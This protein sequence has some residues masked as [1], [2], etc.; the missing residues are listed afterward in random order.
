MM[1]SG[2]VPSSPGLLAS[3]S[4]IPPSIGITPTLPSTAGL[5]GGS[6][7]LQA[8]PASLVLEPPPLQLQPVQFLPSQAS[9]PTTPAIGLHQLPDSRISHG[10]FAPPLSPTG[11]VRS[12]AFPM[13]TG[14][15][16]D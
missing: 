13:P 1:P 11:A 12:N 9:L 3:A 6:A 14:G 16:E 7:V 4:G 2:V 15:G 8:V 10:S 5:G